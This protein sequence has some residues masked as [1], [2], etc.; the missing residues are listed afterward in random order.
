M[1]SGMRG[2]K[3]LEEEARTSE[4]TRDRWRVTSDEKHAHDAKNLATATSGMHANGLNNALKLWALYAPLFH[5]PLRVP[6]RTQG[7][8]G[9]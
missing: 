1:I 7:K 5:Q 6:F 8:D 9:A 2:A 3:E 4:L